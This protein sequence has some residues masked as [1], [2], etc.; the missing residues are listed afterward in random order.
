MIVTADIQAI[1]QAEHITLLED[2][3]WSRRKQ[4]TLITLIATTT[5]GTVTTSGTTVTG[6]GTSFTSSMVNQFIR[7]GSNTF[8]HLITGFTSTTVITIEAALPADITTAT[9]YT[10]FQHLY[11]LP[12][13]FGR[14][15]NVMSDIRLTEWARSEIERVDPY[16]SVTGTRP[17]IYTT[18][19][20]NSSNVFQI[21]FWPVPSSAQTIRIE[22]LRTN[23]LTN[24]TDVPLYRSDILVWKSAESAAFF[25][26]GKTGDAAWLAL[27]DRYHQRFAESMQSAREDDLGRFSVPAY[28]RD[29][30]YSFGR[31]DDFW[32]DRDPIFL[33]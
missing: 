33:R 11:T 16:R 32:I 1:I 25:L 19:G 7:I 10:I 29:K 20:P 31:G 26:H 14:I 21:E 3:S 15:T 22:Y 2:Y 18:R 4:D 23:T 28:V 8:Y 24:S 17:D 6:S 30:A 5:T 9:A 27:A 13:D 12:S